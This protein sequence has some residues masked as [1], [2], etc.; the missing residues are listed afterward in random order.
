[1]RSM[2]ARCLSISMAS[3]WMLPLPPEAY[4]SGGLAEELGEPLS[5]DPRRDIGRASRR[6]RHDELDR[7]QGVLRPR[8][9]REQGREREGSETTRSRPH[10]VSSLSSLRCYDIRRS[11]KTTCSSNIALN[12]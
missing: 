2:P 3:W 4:A 7:P 12:G 10:A 8:S 5:D 11:G 1:M 6:D 9:G